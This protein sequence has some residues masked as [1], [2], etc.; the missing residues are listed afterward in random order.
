MN[1]TD[2]TDFVTIQS[3]LKIQAPIDVAIKAVKSV[4]DTIKM[5]IPVPIK[6]G[7]V[8][9]GAVVGPALGQVAKILG[10]APINATVNAVKGVGEA[11]GLGG[12]KKKIV[13]E[14]VALRFAPGYA[15]LNEGAM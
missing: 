10:M 13:E 8:S 5:T 4:D 7:D 9:Y 1:V 3:A 2:V 15:G 6:H 12:D 11:M 14:T